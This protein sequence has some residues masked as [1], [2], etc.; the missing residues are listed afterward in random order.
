MYPEPAWMHIYTN[1]SLL[2]ASDSTGGGM[3]SHLFSFYLTIG[4]FTTAFDGEVGALQ[5]VLAQLH[6]HVNSFTMAFVFCDSKATIF[7]GNSNSPPTSSKVLV[8]KKLLQSLSEYSKKIVLQWIPGHCGVTGNE[9][10]D[11]L[12]KNGASIQQTTRK[13]ISKFFAPKVYLSKE[14]LLS[15]DHIHHKNIKIPIYFFNTKISQK[16]YKIPLHN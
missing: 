2:K 4:K 16:S 11:H 6:C 5:V 14:A 13:R 9:F 3:H 1:G 12:A 8:C 10:A 7:A 15:L